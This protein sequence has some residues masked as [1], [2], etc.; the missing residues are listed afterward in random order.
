MLLGLVP[1]WRPL[2]G[3]PVGTTARIRLSNLFGS[4][5]VSIAD[6]HVALVATG[7]STQSG[8][9]RVVTF[10]GSGSVTIGAGAEVNS[11]SVA[12]TIPSLSE[13][14]VSFYLPNST[15]VQTYHQLGMQTTYVASGDVSG[16][17][18]LSV[19]STPSSYFYLTNLD[20]Q[21]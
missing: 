20:V 8:T 11:D 13:L 17:T 2:G 19:V 12:M 3:L 4:Q 14:A 10:G 9:D 15:A 5:S 16:N 21:G 1:R 7:S 6:V 18:S